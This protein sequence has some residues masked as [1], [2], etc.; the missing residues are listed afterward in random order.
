MPAPLLIP[1]IVCQHRP[2][3]TVQMHLWVVSVVIIPDAASA[4]RSAFKSFNAG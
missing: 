1:V 2:V 3:Q 4:Q